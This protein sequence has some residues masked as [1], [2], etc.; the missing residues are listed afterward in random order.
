M[1]R[2]VLPRPHEMGRP[3]VNVTVSNAI[4]PTMSLECVALVDTGASHLILPRAWRSKLGELETL[5]VLQTETATQGKVRGEICG[6]VLL[7]VEGF[8]PIST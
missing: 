1:F 7:E 5:R 3:L 8:R 2:K 4:D 6:P